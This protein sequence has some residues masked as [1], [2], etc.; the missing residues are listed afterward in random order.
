[1]RKNDGIQTDPEIPKLLGQVQYYSRIF[2]TADNNTAPSKRNKKQDLTSV[3]VAKLA[4]KV[5]LITPWHQNMIKYLIW[6]WD[7]SIIQIITYD[8]RR[9][10]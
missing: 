1:M 6:Q 2:I 7:R 8:A 10:S 3:C 4:T 9:V 5:I